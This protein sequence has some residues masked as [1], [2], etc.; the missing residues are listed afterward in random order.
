MND[1]PS[2]VSW[3]YN[4]NIDYKGNLWVTDQETNTIFYISKE[5][6][7]FNALFKISGRELRPGE[8]SARNGNLAKATFKK[9]SS[10]AIYDRNETRILE[11]KNLIPVYL[12]SNET[13]DWQ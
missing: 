9:P 6:E 4:Y 3:G 5:P 11:M 8:S 1:K 2:L 10:V 7:S 13:H 12:L